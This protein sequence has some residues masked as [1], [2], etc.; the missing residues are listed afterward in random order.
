M[1]KISIIVFLG[2]L[3]YG[4]GLFNGFVWDDEVM[5][6]TGISA[7]AGAYF[8]PVITAVYWT[9]YNIFGAQPFVFHFIQL[10]F[11][12]AAAVL[13]YHL[14]KR[15]FK[16]TISLVLALIF[17]V[18]PSNVEA[19]SFASAMQEIGFTLV[20]II[21]LYLFTRRDVINHVSTK[22]FIGTFLLLIALLMK[23]TGIVFF[24]LVFFYLILFKKNNKAV[25]ISYSV[26]SVI[27]LAG[28]LLFRLAAGNNYVAGQGLFPI[29]R[30]SLSTRLINIPSIIFYYITKFFYPIN[31]EIAQHWVVRA[32][33]IRNFFLPLI[34][35]IGLF[36]TAVIYITKSKNKLFLFFFLWF[37]IGLI[38]HLQIIPLN[39]TVAER[40]LYFPMIGLLGVIGV[41]L[42]EF[43]IKNLELRIIH[44]GIIIIFIFSVRSFIRTL[45]WRNGLSLF[46][47]DIREDSSFDLQN[48]MGVELFRVGRYAE[49]KKYFETSV[50]LA[51]YWWVNWNNLGVS[52][53]REKNYQKAAEYYQ[54]SVNNGQYYLAYENLARILVKYG[55]DR[56][57]TA[58]FIDKALK[59]YPR[60]DN[61]K[62]IENYF[63]RERNFN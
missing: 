20:G 50:K 27:L 21:G 55:K 56:E 53:E 9:I 35:E 48:N 1:K 3:V 10:I 22:I 25:L 18:H 5:F 28:Y 23:E 40:W 45:D 11:H 33:D 6:Q 43:R 4:F 14:F 42:S 36:L 17:L 41:I 37:L 62:Q 26:F 16:E 2:L 44:I 29:M 52:Y 63:Q 15:F 59:V 38:P 47:R 61:L 54:R 51:P 19:V 34:F 39:M 32:V 13:V 12:T 57:K 49:A 30:V 60:D 7:Q 46:S 31:L 58:D 8:R 24:V